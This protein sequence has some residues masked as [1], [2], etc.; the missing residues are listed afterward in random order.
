MVAVGLDNNR[1][2][3][4]SSEDAVRI[5]RVARKMHLAAT[6]LNIPGLKDRVQLRIGIHSGPLC[7]GVVGSTRPRYCLFGDTVNVASRMESTG[8][9]GHVQLSKVRPLFAQ[10]CTSLYT[11]RVFHPCSYLGNHC[12]TGPVWV[13]KGE[14]WFATCVHKR[15]A[16]RQGERDVSLIATHVCYDCVLC[17]DGNLGGSASQAQNFPKFAILLLS[18]ALW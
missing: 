13:I 11:P 16:I 10:R 18:L 15:L 4:V 9:P 7:S 12:S 3:D 17:V 1:D 14:A 2:N 5:I 8:V 6:L